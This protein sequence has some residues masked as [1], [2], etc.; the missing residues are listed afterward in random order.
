[1]K[2]NSMLTAKTFFKM[3]ET[4]RKL[5]AVTGVVNTILTVSLIVKLAVAVLCLCSR[6]K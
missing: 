3:A 1:M 5:L 2:N 4:D 6:E